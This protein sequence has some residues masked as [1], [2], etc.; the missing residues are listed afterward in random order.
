MFLPDEGI[1]PLL[2]YWIGKTT[3]AFSDWQLGLYIN[4]GYTPSAASHF[5]DLVQPYWSG[6]AAVT[7]TKSM[8]AAAA[9]SGDKAFSTWGSAPVTWTVG[10][11]PLTVYGWMIWQPDTSKLVAIQANSSGIVTATGGIISMTPRLEFLSEP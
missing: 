6:Y 5:A 11:T 8:W 3:N 2:E 1:L 4:S 7:L 10:T 9:L